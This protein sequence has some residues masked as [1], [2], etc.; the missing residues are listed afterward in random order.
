MLRPPKFAINFFR[1]FCHPRLQKP[2][3]GDLM[4]LYDERAKEFG[5]A[6]ADR[7]FVFDVLQLFRPGIIRPTEGTYRLNHYGMFKNHLKTSLRS[8]NK[9]RLFSSINIAGLAI[10][11]SV[12]ILM[13]LF[14][15]E[16]Y[17]FDDFHAQ[18]DRIY[19]VTTHSSVHSIELNVCASSYYMGDQ[20]AAQIPEVEKILIMRPGMSADMKTDQGAINV[21]GY[22]AT[23]SFF[24]VFSF[25]LKKG[26]PQTALSDPNSIVLTESVS[27]KI[28]GDLDPMGQSLDLESSGGYQNRTIKGTITGIME[29]LPYNSHIQFEALVSFETYDQPAPGSGWRSNYK[30]DP[31]DFQI[32][33]VYLVLNEAAKK[34]EVEQAMANIM[35]D[36]NS[37]TERP[38]VNLLQPLESFLT[39][40]LYKNRG[41]SFSKERI[42]AMIGLTFIVFLS[43]CF[44][45]TN[46]SLARGLR[47]SKEVSIR[48]V[49]GANKF[50][51]FSQFMVEAILIAL[52][53]LVIGI[54]IFFLLKPEFLNLPNPTSQ[55]FK[56]YLLDIKLIHVLYFILFAIA[57]GCLAGFLPAL[58]LSRLKSKVIFGD[59]SRSKL[60]SGVNLR[61]SL[62]IGQFALS[63]GFIMCAVISYKQYHFALNYDLG[64]DTENII[65]VNIKGEYG[66]LLEN[67]YSKMPEVVQTSRS[68][69]SL[70]VG[71]I[72]FSPIQ[73]EDKS[74]Q[75]GTFVNSIDEKYLEMYGFELL[76]GSVF[77]ATLKKGEDPTK[78]IVN[79]ALLKNLSLGSP[80]E[81]IGKHVWIRGRKYKISGVVEDFVSVGLALASENEIFQNKNFAFVQ[82]GVYPD[83]H[84]V[85][86]IKIKSNDILATIDKLETSYNALDPLHPFES[87]F[88][89]VSIAKTYQQYKTTYTIIS[90]LTF[91]AISISTLGLLGMAVFTTETRMKEISIRKVLGAGTHNLMLLLSRG[92][93]WMLILAGLIAIPV[94]LYAAEEVVLADFT[95][96]V[97]VGLVEALSGFVIVLLIGALT[98]GWQIREAAVQNPA[99]LLRDE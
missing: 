63:M 82:N 7:K 76:A 64:F 47:R 74:A 57:I 83:L 60:F 34:E 78:V 87:N 10:S 39:D 99:D 38:I 86:G 36:Y 32:S 58:F 21:S 56:M 14:L 88:Y 1:W 73:S 59:V 53:A 49:A 72:E 2:I 44:N 35:F 31:N 3:E 61:R 15:S 9:N 90:F 13:I 6:K 50:Q 77:L 16:I 26:N 89:N 12:G 71:L 97:E 19:R 85:L 22:Y 84:G 75:S 41:P 65:H 95:H 62:I 23:P 93:F 30:T 51:V 33:Y 98:I 5:K 29:D 20:I 55:G 79:R 11:M 37:K 48:K 46:L 68:L 67:E 69:L 42:Y 25:R 24:D 28:F 8:L 27:K 17:S 43:A 52:I 92:F 94:G 80:H 18:K 91:L 54:G 70:G 81:S 96:R 40:D 4:E 45:Y 66:H